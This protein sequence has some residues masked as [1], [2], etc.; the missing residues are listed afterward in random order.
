MS[1]NDYQVCILDEMDH[2]NVV[3]IHEF[4]TDDPQYN[5]IVLDLVRGGDLFHHFGRK[6]RYML[7]A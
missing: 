6:V 4:Y 7:F 1:T 2:E 5:Y 3:K